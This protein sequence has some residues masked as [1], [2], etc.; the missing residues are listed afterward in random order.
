MFAECGAFPRG[1]FGHMKRVGLIH[2]FVGSVLG[3]YL[4]EAS[5]FDRVL[6]L[7]IQLLFP[8]FINAT[9]AHLT[10]SMTSAA[11]KNWIS[12]F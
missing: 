9:M 10:P 3:F 2:E 4:S 8:P 12:G 7:Q 1:T 6:A 5:P 11:R